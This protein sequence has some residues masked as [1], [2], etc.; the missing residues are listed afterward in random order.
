MAAT[1]RPESSSDGPSVNSSGFRI[2]PRHAVTA[3]V[4]ESQVDWCVSELKDAG[5]SFADIE[6]LRGETGREIFDLKGTYHGL[7]SR[8]IRTAQV[9]GS[10]HNEMLNYDAGLRDGHAVILVHVADETQ[11]P[12]AAH[13][14]VVHQGDRVLAFGGKGGEVELL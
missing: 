11:I 12:A 13:I 9:V 6:I 4:P 3:I 8:V 14:F 5:F 2:G 1:P 7:K 10:V